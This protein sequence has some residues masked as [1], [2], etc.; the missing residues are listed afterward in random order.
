[1]NALAAAA[2]RIIGKKNAGRGA[3]G[4][5]SA[6]QEDAWQMYDN[7]GELRFIV[8]ALASQVGKARLYAAEL[9]ENG[10]IVP[11]ENEN[12]RRAVQLI[13]SSFADT[14]Q[15]LERAAQ[16]ILISGEFWFAGLPPR[17]DRGKRLP[18]SEATMKELDWHMLSVS[19]VS[20]KDGTVEIRLP[21]GEESLKL[22]D[23][24]LVRVHRPHPRFYGQAVS[25]V[26]SAL[27]ILRELVGLTMHISAQV[28][29]RLAGAGVFIV[30]KSAQ[31]TNLENAMTQAYGGDTAQADPV[32]EAMVE[33]MSAALEDR[34][35]A[36][37]IVPIVLSVPDEAVGK[38]Q[39][40]SFASELDKNAEKL[41]EESIRRLALSMDA[42]PE[43]LLGTAD[44]NHWSSWLISEDT[45]NSHVTPLL[46]LLADALTQQFLPDMLAALGEKDAAKYFVWF[47]V[48]HLKARPNRSAEAVSL[49][50]RGL[51]GA[52]ATREANG[53]EESDV[54]QGAH[55]RV[56]EM[57]TANPGLLASPGVTALVEQ[58][59]AL[60]NGDT[61]ALEPVGDVAETTAR[62]A[63]T[64]KGVQPVTLPESKAGEQ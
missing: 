32:T 37:A 9:D 47:D 17:G 48:D 52:R 41:R 49:Y 59:T 2:T 60:M 4:G 26:R 46:T 44:M 22:D 55:E 7:V 38:F 19:E 43:M 28:D 6:W 21:E 42:P 23:I 64:S 10:E 54:V 13:G 62:P 40:I 61:A 25:P 56:L 51:I 63:E 27:P 29:S 39:H 50:D 12:A 3:R 36:A 45:V 1:M 53:F 15:M 16:N 31:Q 35:T 11:S 30:P 5:S 8:N 14:A 24:Y 18:L 34:G 57:V 20:K 58:I 33:A